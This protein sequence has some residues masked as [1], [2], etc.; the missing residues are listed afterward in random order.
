MSATPCWLQA[1]LRDAFRKGNLYSGALTAGTLLIPY[2]IAVEG[3][4]Q[5][6]QKCDVSDVATALGLSK[7]HGANLGACVGA[8]TTS[9]IVAAGL[10]PIEKQIV[11]DQL[12]QTR[13]VS[14]AKSRNAVAEI[15]R[16]AR[17]NGVRALYQGFN[18]LFV[19]ELI[20]I[21][22]VTVL[23]PYFTNRLAHSRGQS[24]DDG[25]GNKAKKPAI[26]TLDGVATG[27][28]IGF[29]AGIIS[30]PCQTINAIMKDER[31]RYDRCHLHLGAC[32]TVNA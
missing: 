24:D 29:G 22:A 30:A 23:T 3:L 5:S 27:F 10:Q 15:T 20:Y 7:E 19:R 4:T 9:F 14:S 26:I 18:A 17:R 13:K 2:S 8:T 21:G 1:T 31:H 32:S 12:L 16:Y 28:C 11:M 6:F 25:S